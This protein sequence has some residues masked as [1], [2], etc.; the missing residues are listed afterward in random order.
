MLTAYQA[1]NIAEQLGF[2][3][4]A[5]YTLPDSD[6]W[7]EYYTPLQA[8]FEQLK[9]SGNPAIHEVIA[10]ETTEINLRKK[11]GSEY[12]YVGFVLSQNAPESET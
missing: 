4:E 5:T 12:G 11:Y 2:T 1:A 10:M 3:V 8:R 7:D 9:N 6:W